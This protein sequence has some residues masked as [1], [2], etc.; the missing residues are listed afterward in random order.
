ME[1]KT[2]FVAGGTKGERERDRERVSERSMSWAQGEKPTNR[3][4]KKKNTKTTFFLD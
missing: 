2:S 4:H 3:K 1:K